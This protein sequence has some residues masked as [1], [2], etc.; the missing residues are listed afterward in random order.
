MILESYFEESQI[1]KLLYI[2]IE[3]RAD[4]GQGEGALQ[5]ALEGFDYPIEYLQLQHVYS[6]VWKLLQ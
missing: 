1:S 3:C 4:R 5:K 6:I 2:L